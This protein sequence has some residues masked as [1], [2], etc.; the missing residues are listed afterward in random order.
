MRSSTSC[1]LR[2]T[3]SCCVLESGSAERGTRRSVGSCANTLGRQVLGVTQT[4]SLS[5]RSREFTLYVEICVL[6]T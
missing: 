6:G 2:T 4:W 5:F 1:K 3:R